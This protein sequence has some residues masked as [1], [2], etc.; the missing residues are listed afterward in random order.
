ME[1]DAVIIGDSIVWHVRATVAKGKVR[2][3]CLPGARVLN[4]SAQVPMILKKNIGAVVLHA[5]MN[6]I[7]LRK[8]EI[9][10]KDFRSLVEK[11]CNT[12]PTT[13]IIMSGPLPMFQRGIES[14]LGSTVLMACTQ[15]E[16]E[17]QSSQT[18]SPGH[19]APSDCLVQF[20]GTPDCL[21]KEAVQQSGCVGSNASGLAIRGG[22]IP[23]P[24][25]D[26]TAQDAFDG[27]SVKGG[28]DERWKMSLPQPSQEVETLLGFLGDEAGVERSSEVLHQ[29]NTEEF[30]AFDDLHVGPVDVQWRMVAL[31][32][33]EV[34][35][36]LFHFLHFQRQVVVFTPS[37]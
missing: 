19:Y 4:V 25:S 24:G 26:A 15:A 34:N 7:R 5:G 35:N 13:R 30:G 1:C 9:L 23:K 31:C 14:V 21:R 8:T 28:Q 36:D 12:L 20:S 27:P 37:C 17:Q 16:L 22:A 29:V 10:K 3:R 18:T 32:S 33:S 11:V 6:D 2:T